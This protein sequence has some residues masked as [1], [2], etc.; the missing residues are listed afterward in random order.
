MLHKFTTLA[1]AG[2]LALTTSCNAPQATQTAAPSAATAAQD[3][4]TAIILA[5]GGV[6]V[7]GRP[8]STDPAQAVYVGA[9]IVYYRDGTDDTYGEGTEDEK[10][11]AAEAEAHTVVTLTQPGTY[12]IEGTLSQGQIAVDLGD[13]AKDDPTAV[14]TL[15]LDNADVTCTVAPALIFYNVYECDR[16]FVAGG[17]SYQPTSTVDTAEAGANV[18]IAAGSVNTFQGSHVARIYQEGTTKKLHK[19]DGAFYSKMSMNIFGDSGDDSGVLN[20]VGDSEGLDTELHLTLNGGTVNVTS[21]DDGIN[22]NEDNVSVTTVNG[23]TLTVHA[24]NGAEGDGIDSNGHLVINGGSV[25]TFASDHSMDGGIDADGDMLI[26]GGVVCAYGVRNDATSKN[27]RQTV[28]EFSLSSPLDQ[29][30]VLELKDGDGNV[31]WSDAAQGSYRAL[32][33]SLPELTE[34]STYQL[35]VDGAL[36]ENSPFGFGHGGMGKPDLPEDFDPSQFDGQRPQRGDG[37]R[38]QRPDGERPQPPEGFD[39]SQFD[40]R[41]PQR[42]ERPDAQR[43]PGGE[44]PSQPAQ[45]E[46]AAETDAAGI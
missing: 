8:A 7:D 45:A 4:Q 23:G 17:D 24:G 16:A 34:D 5:D 10:H 40:D 13:E 28:L 43:F 27:S 39:P 11:P 14:V 22:T 1:L 37:E 46:T 44:L 35:Y 25:T 18:V 42:G 20:I 19:Y 30:S 29:G 36:Q 38:P 9:N 33:L 3:V 15:I 32:T 21:Q 41:R 6:T 2:L 12:R 26:N 31:I